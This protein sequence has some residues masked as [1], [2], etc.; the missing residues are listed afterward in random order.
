[1]D[2]RKGCVAHVKGMLGGVEGVE[3]VVLCQ[4]RLK[5]SLEVDECKPLPVRHPP[6]ALCMGTPLSYLLNVEQACPADRAWQ[7]LLATSF[8]AHQTLTD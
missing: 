1:M 6:D 4:T 5:L 8:N 7:I 2:V 3:V